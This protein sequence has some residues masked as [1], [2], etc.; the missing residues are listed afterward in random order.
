MAC[1]FCQQDGGS[2]QLYQ[3]KTLEADKTLRQMATDL[4]ETELMARIE[5]GDHVALEAKYHLE[6]LTALRN[7]YRSFKL[8][9]GKVYVSVQMP[10]ANSSATGNEFKDRNLF[11]L[12]RNKLLGFDLRIFYIY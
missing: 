7:Y 11:T 6:C 9:L 10:S 2:L 1:L 8:Q 3:F 12:C 4:Q 5:G